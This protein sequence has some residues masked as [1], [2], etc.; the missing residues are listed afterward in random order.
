MVTPDPYALPV[1]AWGDVPTW[2]AVVGA[3]A[4]GGA[5]LWQLQLQRIQLTDATRIQE[6]QQADAIDVSAGS[7]DG[8]MSECLPPGDTQ[9]CTW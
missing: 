9:A 4:G 8:V 7:I 5:A 2:L 1:V 6:R 3:F